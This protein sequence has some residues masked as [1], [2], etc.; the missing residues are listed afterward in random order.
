MKRI[1]TV[2]ILILILLTACSVDSTKEAED[3]VKQYKEQLYSISDYSKFDFTNNQSSN[4]VT[5]E[6]EKYFTNDGYSLFSAMRVPINYRAAAFNEKYNLKLKSIELKKD[7][8]NKKDN[9]MGFTYVATISVTD[10]KDKKEESVKEEGYVNL[11]KVDG[12][13]KLMVDKV[14]KPLKRQ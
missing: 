5:K 13:W 12:K 4:E 10:P 7:Y 2:F 11:A 6:F 8:E 3:I 1:I 14:D 9:L